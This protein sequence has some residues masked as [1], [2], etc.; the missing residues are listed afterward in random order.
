MEI[1]VFSQTKQSEDSDCACE[2][3]YE[4][5]SEGVTMIVSNKGTIKGLNNYGPI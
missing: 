2:A 5:I 3:D 1:H 4:G